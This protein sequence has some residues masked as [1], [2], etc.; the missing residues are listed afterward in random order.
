[1]LRDKGKRKF[2]GNS[3]ILRD[4]DL[5][6]VITKEVQRGSQFSEG[7]VGLVLDKLFCM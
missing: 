2:I 3:E 7:R 4:F 5:G 1:M 6:N